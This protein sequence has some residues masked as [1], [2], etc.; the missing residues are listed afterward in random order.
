MLHLIYC[1]NRDAAQTEMKLVRH[2]IEIG[3]AGELFDLDNINQGKIVECLGVVDA[4]RGKTFPK[5]HECTSKG[6]RWA[7]LVRTEYK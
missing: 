7:V 1:D 2:A 3:I 5:S 6:L 4:G